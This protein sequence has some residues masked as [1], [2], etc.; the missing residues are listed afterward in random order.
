MLRFACFILAISSVRGSRI[1]GGQ[2]AS[3]EKFPYTV[4]IEHLGNHLC[5]G[6]ILSPT[7]VLTAAHCT[8]Y[9][10][11]DELKVGAGNSLREQGGQLITLIDKIE[12]PDFNNGLFSNDVG[13]LTLASVLELSDK[14]GGQSQSLEATCFRNNCKN[15]W[16]P[17]PANK[18]VVTLIFG[19]SILRPWCALVA[20][21]G[22][23]DARSY[24]SGGPVVVDGKQVGVVSTGLKQCSGKYP[25][26]YAKLGHFKE[27]IESW[28]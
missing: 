10:Q 18:D 19:L 7:K 1:V 25:I 17:R 9:Y 26:L 20:R 21:K 3:I 27:M 16:L 23:A 22:K 4:S 2:N 6:S 13:V 12:H 24:D 14:G 28:M 11:L 15:C 8:K 5:L